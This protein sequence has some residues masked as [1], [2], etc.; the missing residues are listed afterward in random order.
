MFEIERMKYT[1]K[2]YIYI[3]TIKQIINIMLRKKENLQVWSL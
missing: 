2:V 1:K 3:R